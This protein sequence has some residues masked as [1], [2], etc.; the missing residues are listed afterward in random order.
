MAEGKAQEVSLVLVPVA[1]VAESVQLARV[2]LAPNPASVVLRLL[3]V[4]SAI[5]YV[6]YSQQ[7]VEVMRGALTGEMTVGLD[8]SKLPEGV[9]VVRVEA[10]DGWRALRFV[11]RR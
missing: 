4:E 7:G 11:V 8:V 2:E 10:A 6:V 3:H 9:Y 5:G 1:S